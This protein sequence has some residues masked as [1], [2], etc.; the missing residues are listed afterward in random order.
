MREHDIY[1]LKDE[2]IKGKVSSGFEEAKEFAKKLDFEEVKSGEWFVSLLQR[3]VRTYDRNARAQYFQQKYPGLSPDDIA[4]ILIS[5]TVR[6]AGIAGG[7][8]GAAATANQISVI[9]SAGMTVPL[10]LG[11]IGAEMIYL[12]RIQMRL[13]LDLSVVY[14]LQLNP[15]DP[16]DV[17]MVFGYA[18]GITPTEVIG[19]GASKAAGEVTK[20]A[21]KKHIS[22]DVLKAIQDFARR[23]GFKILQRTIL[24][25]VVP[26]VSAAVGSS[27]NY[28]TTKAL[29]KITKTHFKNR[30]KVT[31]ELRTLVSR[32]NTYDL[33]FPA[34]AMYMAQVDGEFSLEEKELYRAMLSRMSFEE[35]TQAEFQKLSAN[36]A[37]LL[38]AAAQ[39]EDSDVQRSL[40]DLLAM[41]A[42]YDGKLADKER[43]FLINISDRLSVPLNLE[44]I[45]R[46][47]KDYQVLS[48]R[49]I[50]D[51]ATKTAGG[52]SEKILDRA[53]RT[54]E[55]ARNLTTAAGRRVK[56]RLGEVL[57]RDKE[58]DTE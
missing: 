29:G 43:E 38:K 16:E 10:F 37:D 30:A 44:A 15:E 5:V 26:V 53:E 2:E 13:V 34:A 19:T 55:G 25:Y 54:V 58:K 3:V 46:R 47:S 27:Y 21:I 50:F 32:Q 48:N 23:L 57:R 51:R 20:R 12:A 7:I 4:D 8:A 31:E 1:D 40:V 56:G 45:E 6:Y 14:D 9:A 39:I 33:V 52:A 11:T 22:K 35:H 41:M 36:E 24:K 49:N 42:V 18:L 28:A 17:L